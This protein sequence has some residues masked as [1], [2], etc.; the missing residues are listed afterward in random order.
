MS[1]TRTPGSSGPTAEE[2]YPSIRA[3]RRLLLQHNH[4]SMHNARIV[5]PMQHGSSIVAD[6]PAD[7]TDLAFAICKVYETKI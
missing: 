4:P 7:F 2:T 5:N 6:D 1:R 3:S